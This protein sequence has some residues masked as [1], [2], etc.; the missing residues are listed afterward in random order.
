MYNK[1][2]N[3][4][5]QVTLLKG[6]YIKTYGTNEKV[7]EET[8]TLLAVSCKS[9]GGTEKVVNGQ[10]VIEDTFVIETNYRNDITSSDGI[11]MNGEVYEIINRPEN[12]NMENRTLTFKVRRFSGKY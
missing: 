5:T 9:Y 4:R 1:E 6:S 10:V 12:I 3:Y 11:K 8:K 7:L 2:A